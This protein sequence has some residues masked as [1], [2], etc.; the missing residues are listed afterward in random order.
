M[1]TTRTFMYVD[2]DHTDYYKANVQDDQHY[3]FSIFNCDNNHNDNN[4]I[5]N[6]YNDDTN[7]AIYHDATI[8]AITIV[9]TI[10]S[11]MMTGMRYYDNKYYNSGSHLSF[12]I[13]KVI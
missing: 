8:M 5:I 6:M 10:L 7:S 4:V 9:L 3:C 11:M 2:Y 12:E 13:S 1:K